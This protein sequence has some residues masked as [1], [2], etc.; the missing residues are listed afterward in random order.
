MSD[1]IHRQDAIDTLNREYTWHDDD[2]PNAFER[3]IGLVPSAG[4]NCILCE[5]YT[6][7]ET[8]DGIK[9]ECTRRTSAETPTKNTNTPTDTPTDLISRQD[10]LDSIRHDPNDTYDAIKSLPLRLTEYKTF[11]GVPIEEAARIVQEHNADKPT[12]DLISRRSAIRWVKTECNPY[13]KPTLDFES[14][15]K[16]IE[17]LE[18]MPSAE[19]KIDEESELKFYYVESIDDYWVGRRLDNFYYANWH[20]GLGFVWSHSRYLPWG[21]HIVDENTLWKEHTYP[22]EPIEIPFTEWIVGFV[23][24]YFA[25]PKTGHWIKDDLGTTICSECG[26]PRRDNRINH[27]KFCNSCGAKML[28]EDGEEE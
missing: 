16:F 2:D 12:T 17:H 24:K 26:R 22:S 3:I 9:G 21:E 20:E 10:A 14:G 25:E 4:Q 6:E 8:D 28:G 27:I 13:G 5:Y 19:P 23:K 18:Q 11:C 15:K 7:I 1:L